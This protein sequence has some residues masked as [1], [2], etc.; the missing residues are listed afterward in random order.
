LQAPGRITTMLL[1]GGGLFITL[2]G[3]WG[4][5]G[6]GKLGEPTVHLSTTE[7]RRGEEI[8]FSL[9][10][11][12]EQKTEIRSLEVILECEERVVHGHGQYQSRHKRTVF[13]KRLTLAEDQTIKPHRGL[14]KKGTLTLPVDAAPSFGAPHNQVIWWLRFRGDIVGWPDWREPVLLTVWP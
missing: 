1:V 6:R 10:I 12:P 9:V 13:E 14:K 2:R 5:L 11:R 7:V 3:F 4:R 8:R